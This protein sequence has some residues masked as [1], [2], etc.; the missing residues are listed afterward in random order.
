M[1]EKELPLIIEVLKFCQH[2]RGNFHPMSRTIRASTM[3][4]KGSQDLKPKSTQKLRLMVNGPASTM[5]WLT[6]SK[7][8]QEVHP[9]PY[10]LGRKSS[11][12]LWHKWLNRQYC[13][14]K[15]SDFSLE[16]QAKCVAENLKNFQFMYKSPDTTH[17]PESILRRDAGVRSGLGF[18]PE[19]HQTAPRVRFGAQPGGPVQGL[20]ICLLHPFVVV[21]AIA[22]LQPSLSLSSLLPR[23]VIVVAAQSSPSSLRLPYGRP[24]VVVVAARSS[25]FI[26]AAVTASPSRH[27]PPLSYCS[28]CL[29]LMAARGAEGQWRD[30]GPTRGSGF[31]DVN[32]DGLPHRSLVQVTPQ[33]TI[34]TAPEATRPRKGEDDG[35]RQ[36]P[37]LVPSCSPSLRCCG[38]CDDDDASLAA[39]DPDHDGP[40]SVAYYPVGST[41]STPSPSPSSSPSPQ[42]SSFIIVILDFEL[43]GERDL[44]QFV[45]V[46]YYFNE[47]NEFDHPSSSTSSTATSSSTPNT[48]VSTPDTKPSST[49]GNSAP[50]TK[51]TGARKRRQPDHDCDHDDPKEMTTKMTATATR[52]QWRRLLTTTTTWRPP[53]HEQLG[54]HDAEGRTKGLH[55]TKNSK[56]LRKP[57]NCGANYIRGPDSRP[58]NS[59]VSAGDYP[60]CDLK[61]RMSH[62]VYARPQPDSEAAH[63]YCHT[64]ANRLIEHHRVGT[65]TCKSRVSLTPT[66]ESVAKIGMES[67]LRAAKWG[68]KGKG[69][70]HGGTSTHDREHGWVSHGCRFFVRV[71]GAV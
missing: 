41:S 29:V 61:R 2:K 33:I 16:D 53:D 48:P 22:A 13:R 56:L 12:P 19:P 5:D 4:S 59:S 64:A 51:T 28:R 55:R 43:L 50:R 58:F 39:S 49:T 35:L 25:L 40:D 38:T 46:E 52:W 37:F 14:R 62:E 44:I 57:T 26:V 69:G 20:A 15:H 21:A 34:H 27:H 70:D 66:A 6:P 32:Y 23:C 9:T 54:D 7:L 31:G 47:L 42:P 63:R 60:D 30:R 1:K 68:G 65:R 45:H 10:Q 17:I 18:G 67:R 8:V 11:G 24:I 36:A 71:R 3:L